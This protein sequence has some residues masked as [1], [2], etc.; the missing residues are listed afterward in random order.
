M[1]VKSMPNQVTPPAPS[2]QP[3][4]GRKRGLAPH[5]RATK[6]RYPELP[7]AQVAKRVGCSAS[8]VSQVMKRFLRKNSFADL[9]EFQA[10]RANIYDAV[11]FQ[12]LASITPTKLAKSSAAQLVTMAAI[13][14]DKRRLT[15]GQ[16]TSLHV[17]ALIDVLKAIREKRVVGHNSNTTGSEPDDKNAY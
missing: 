17:H 1:P 13:L 6:L 8:N 9:Q 12:A 2:D 7:D 4:P 3:I 10:E 14:E 16:P 11:Q 5:I 15:L